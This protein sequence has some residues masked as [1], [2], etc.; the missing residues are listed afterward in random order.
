MR[1]RRIVKVLDGGPAVRLLLGCHLPS[2]VQSAGEQNSGDEHSRKQQLF[3]PAQLDIEI[4]ATY[5]LAVT[6][7]KPVGAV[8]TDVS[9][10]QKKVF[11]LSAM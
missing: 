6:M 7:V 10:I 3:D 9:S 5:P 8:Q 1:F 4:T 11:L 2:N